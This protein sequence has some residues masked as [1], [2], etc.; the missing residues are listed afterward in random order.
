MN[1]CINHT[2]L[3]FHFGGCCGLHL[4]LRCISVS[5]ASPLRFDAKSINTVSDFVRI[6]H[7]LLFIQ[8]SS[9]CQHPVFQRA[10]WLKL[11]HGLQWK[12]CMNHFTHKLACPRPV[13]QLEQLKR[14]LSMTE[15]NCFKAELVFRLTVFSQI[16]TLDLAKLSLQLVQLKL[17]VIAL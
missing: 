5:T 10:I 2:F 9:K 16:L 4:L 12:W 3:V 8:L 17:C 7:D 11:Q 15:N 6:G 1:I 13:C 14:A